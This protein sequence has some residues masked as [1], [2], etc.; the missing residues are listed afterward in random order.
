[1]L[2]SSCSV[3]G[4]PQKFEFELIQTNSPQPG[5]SSEMGL[6]GTSPGSV[7]GTSSHLQ[8]FLLRPEGWLSLEPPLSTSK[9][10]LPVGERKTSNTVG[11]LAL[12]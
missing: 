11:L 5:C 10:P 1:M 2:P 7:L 9:K 8:D 6:G 3:V 12:V 4:E